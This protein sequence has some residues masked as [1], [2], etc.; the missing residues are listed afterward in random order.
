MRKPTAEGMARGD[1]AL[2]TPTRIIDDAY[3]IKS[4]SR[5]RKQPTAM[6]AGLNVFT[7]TSEYWV[8]R[9]GLPLRRQPFNF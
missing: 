3:R 4:P 5:A 1:R 7:T 2:S 6:S 8:F 9:S